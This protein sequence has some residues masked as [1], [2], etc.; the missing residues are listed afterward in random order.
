MEQL[1]IA[2]ETLDADG[3]GAE[4]AMAAGRVARR[5]TADR[6]FQRLAF[7]HG[8]H[9]SNGADEAR[10]LEAGPG[11]G[12]RPGEIVDGARE[13]GGEDL[14]GGAAEVDLPGGEVLALGSL[15]QVERS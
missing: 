10:A 14:R 3:A 13:N 7:E 12:A 6:K 8:H 5:N 2:G 1:F 15:D 9:P 11:H 4:K